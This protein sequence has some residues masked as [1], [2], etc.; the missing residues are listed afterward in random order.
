MRLVIL[1]GSGAGKGTQARRLSTQLGIPAIATGEILRGAIAAE[2]TLG[3]KAKAYVEKGELVPD[4]MMIQ[5]MRQRLLESDV[6]KGWVLDGYPRTAFQAE[7]LDFL[8]S[9][10]AQRLDW[11]IYLQVSET[12]MMERSL[13]R[14]L[15]DDRPE[16]LQRRLQM[17]RDRTIPILEYYDHSQRLL[18]IP[19][20]QSPAQVEQEILSK[21]NF[22]S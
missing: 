6:S 13:A 12:V 11:A 9:D 1:G 20:E 5:F 15:P 4:E 14:S 18:T 22:I 19:A 3:Q 2:T 8:L 21:L 10:L 16:I 7:E 17:F